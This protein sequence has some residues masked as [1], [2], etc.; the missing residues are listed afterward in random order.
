MAMK[1]FEFSIVFCDNV[2]LNEQLEDIVYGGCCDDGQ[3]SSVDGRVMLLFERNA[4]SIV[5][6]VFEVLSELKESGLARHI[7]CVDP[8]DLVSQIQIGKRLG[9]KRQQIHQYVNGLRGPSGFPK[10]IRYT[11][12]RKPVWG[13]ATVLNW[14]VKSNLI[15]VNSDIAKTAEELSVINGFLTNFHNRK[16]FGKAFNN[17]EVRFHEIFYDTRGVE[18]KFRDIPKT[19]QSLGEKMVITPSDKF[20]NQVLGVPQRDEISPY[21]AG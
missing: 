19:F 15:G 2:E 1:N 13:W 20:Y 5:D 8:S 9:K 14:F 6:A 18:D 17:V 21:L 12:E 3:L 11:E 7:L 4:E 16:E 10:P